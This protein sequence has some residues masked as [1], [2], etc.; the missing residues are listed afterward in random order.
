MLCRPC[1]DL[2]ALRPWKQTETL[3]FV[4][5]L[6]PL[7]LSPISPQHGYT[8]LSIHSPN[9]ST[10]VLGDQH[11]WHLPHQQQR[12]ETA[13]ILPSYAQA[14]EERREQKAHLQPNQQ[15]TGNTGAEEYMISREEIHTA[16][17]QGVKTSVL[18]RLV[19]LICINICAG[20]PTLCQLAYFLT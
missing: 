19:S 4:Q 11:Q 1:T 6:P 5:T 15:H 12:G 8:P 17:M 7:S 13:A 10:S 18:K 3:P 14:Q 2:S 9:H 20:S 16:A